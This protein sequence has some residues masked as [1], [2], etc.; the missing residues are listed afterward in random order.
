MPATPRTSEFREL[1]REKERGIPEAKRRKLSR[2]SKRSTPEGERLETLN[3]EYVKE[4]HVVV[5]RHTA[6]YTCVKDLRVDYGC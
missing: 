1:V 5:S 4:A 2:P 6:T 3:K